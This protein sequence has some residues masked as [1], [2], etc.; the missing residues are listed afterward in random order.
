VQKAANRDSVLSY[1]TYPAESIKHSLLTEAAINWKNF[2]K[3]YSSI[4]FLGGKT[5]E[6]RL[7]RAVGDRGRITVGCVLGE[8]SNIHSQLL[9]P[10]V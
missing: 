9:K 5:L 10:A 8:F 3:F 6:R 4:T 7:V 1:K 2:K